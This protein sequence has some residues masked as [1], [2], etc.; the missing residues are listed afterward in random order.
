M[1]GSAIGYL[2]GVSPSPGFFCPPPGG[3]NI[4]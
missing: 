4:S 1:F 3:E 2:E